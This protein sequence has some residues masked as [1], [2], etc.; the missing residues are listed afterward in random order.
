M[1]YIY[2]STKKDGRL[3][4]KAS[5]KQKI[6][7]V[8]FPFHPPSMV[9]RVD[10]FPALRLDRKHAG[11]SL[12]WGETYL[13]WDKRNRKG[14]ARSGDRTRWNTVVWVQDPLK[15]PGRELGRKKNKPEVIF[16][17]S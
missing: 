13:N 3:D 16:L 11:L 4:K 6:N 14:R 9:W 12:W 1:I 15:G 10:C 17:Y 5:M 7:P 2:N 8:W